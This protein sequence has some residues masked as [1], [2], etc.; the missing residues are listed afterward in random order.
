MFAPWQAKLRIQKGERRKQAK[1]FATVEAGAWQSSSLNDTLHGGRKYRVVIPTE[2]ERSA[3]E[4]A[5]G[6]F[7]QI[8]KPCR[9]L[10]NQPTQFATLEI[11]A[12][13]LKA[14]ACAVAF[15]CP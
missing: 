10:P 12:N 14:A 8:R 6:H 4:L 15:S 11:E 3:A 7:S 2:V 9:I 5:R 1:L 13:R